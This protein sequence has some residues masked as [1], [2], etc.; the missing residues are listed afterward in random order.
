MP[1]GL[2]VSMSL[3]LRIIEIS[4]PM[5]ADFMTKKKYDSEEVTHYFHRN[6]EHLIT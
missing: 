5:R 6:D 2:L 4:L 1:Q 3:T